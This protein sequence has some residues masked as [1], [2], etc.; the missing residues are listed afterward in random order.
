MLC[1]EA[2]I[3]RKYGFKLNFG[4]VFLMTVFF[5]NSYRKTFSALKHISLKRPPFS[6]AENSS[7]EIFK[8]WLS[9]LLI[10]QLSNNVIFFLNTIQHADCI[11]LQKK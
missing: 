1:V 11:G 4:S 5:L 3:F 8:S 10:K 6:L 2:Y 9:A 7:C